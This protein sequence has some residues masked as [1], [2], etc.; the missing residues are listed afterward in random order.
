[1]GTPAA[2]IRI[3]F[4]GSA[5]VSAINGAAGNRIRSNSPHD[6]GGLGIDLADDGPTPN[7]AGDA[8]GGPNALQNFP[9]VTSATPTLLRATLSSTASTVF[10]VDFYASGS[11]DP[12][13]YGEGAT[14]VGARSVKTSAAGAATFT[15]A[16]AA[17]VSVGSIV[18]ATATDPAEN[19]SELSPGTSVAAASP[20]PARTPSRT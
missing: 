4:N 6:N 7:D 1:V 15:F 14:W 8:D 17:P 19:T 18:T 3:A 10:V 2:P 12:S 9:F 11:S 16:P 20:A 5:G 13:G